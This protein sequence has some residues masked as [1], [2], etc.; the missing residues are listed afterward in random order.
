MRMGE[1][2]ALFIGHIVHLIILSQVTKVASH[3]GDVTVFIR[4]IPHFNEVTT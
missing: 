1:T 3:C 4:N 2:N